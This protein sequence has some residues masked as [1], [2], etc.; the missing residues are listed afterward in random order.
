MCVYVCVCAWCKDI[1]CAKVV[2]LLAVTGCVVVSAAA[3]TGLLI[4]VRHSRLKTLS[5]AHTLSSMAL[6]AGGGYHTV[7]SVFA[8]LYCF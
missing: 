3:A 5:S 2:R 8:A 1:V 4:E 7:A 6:A